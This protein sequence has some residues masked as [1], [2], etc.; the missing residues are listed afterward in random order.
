MN[1]KEKYGLPE[2]YRYFKRKFSKDER[3]S[4]AFIN[5]K[6]F[7]SILKEFNQ[8]LTALIID[9]AVEF[10]LP[11]RLGYVRI[12][13][14]KKEPHILED[15]TVDKKGMSI[16]WPA[17]KRLWAE[18][19]PGKTKEELKLIHKKPLVY[20]LN[21]HTDGCGFL[22]YWNKKGSNAVNRSV[23]S[24]IFTFSNNRHLAHI[25]KGEKKIDYYE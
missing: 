8:E 19:Y 11:V 14:Y 9:E 13:K 16:D 6:K 20:Y 10:K 4:P 17:S 22:L 23:Y 12:K 5:Y 7:S 1:N 15:G 18:E 3:N 24:M 25:L 2:I 21:E